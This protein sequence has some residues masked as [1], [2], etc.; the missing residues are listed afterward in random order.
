M[1]LPAVLQGFFF[2]L[3]SSTLKRRNRSASWLQCGSHSA[4]SL[5]ALWSGWVW[6]ELDHS[7]APGDFPFHFVHINREAEAGQKRERV[8]EREKGGGGEVRATK[9]KRKE[10]RGKEEGRGGHRVVVFVR[11][12][13]MKSLSLTQRI[14]GCSHISSPHF[15]F[16]TPFYFLL[17]LL[18]SPLFTPS[19][20]LYSPFSLSPAFTVFLSLYLLFL[21]PSLSPFPSSLN[22]APWWRSGSSFSP[23]VPFFFSWLFVSGENRKSQTR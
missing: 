17:L 3:P 5:W 9:G 20:F 23:S 19:L 16:I 4:G 8:K 6:A 1:Q 13:W 12:E 7:P 10:Q 11:G 21:P 22:S 18:V 14:Q 2:F 15:G